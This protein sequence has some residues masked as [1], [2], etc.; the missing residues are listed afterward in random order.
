M[1]RVF[2]CALCE[3]NKVKNKKGIMVIFL[4]HN[5]FFAGLR[6]NISKGRYYFV[7][8]IKDEIFPGYFRGISGVFLV[9]LHL[10]S[11]A[12]GHKKVPKNFT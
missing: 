12:V 5:I 4:R 1:V 11:W 8:A 3:Q 10:E 2:T 9:V 7:T 6:Q